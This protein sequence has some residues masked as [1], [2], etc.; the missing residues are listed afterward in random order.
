MSKVET[1]D[2]FVKPLLGSSH[3]I[4]LSELDLGS[5]LPT[6]EDI[7]K[8]FYERVYSQNG[9]LVAS[10]PE[11]VFI[12]P[13]S[14][15]FTDLSDSYVR[16]EVKL[17]KTHKDPDNKDDTTEIKDTDLANASNLVAFSLWKD[18]T[19]YISGRQ[20][21]SNF[22]LQLYE[23]YLKVLTQCSEESQ[24]KW[25][26]SGYYP[27]RVTSL[28]LP[29]NAKADKETKARYARFGKGKKQVLYMPIL[30]NLCSQMRYLPSLCE[31]KLVLTKGLREMRVIQP[32]ANKAT[33]D[34]E[35]TDIQFVVKRPILYQHRLK[36]LETRLMHGMPC[37]YYIN[38][39]YCRPFQIDE[40]TTSIRLADLL[41]CS[42]LPNYCLVA[43]I[44]SSDLK[45]DV[46]CSNFNFKLFGLQELYF[47]SVSRILPTLMLHF[48][49]FLCA[50]APIIFIF[51]LLYLGL[52]R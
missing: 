52:G 27:E 50:P 29:D 24:R 22:G 26:M 1:H 40:G 39:S 48:S 11:V 28:L 16:M 49:K 31:I 15:H 2:N 44:Q 36:A 8:N 17:V 41:L 10:N 20:V 21:N 13:P 38:N 6:Q 18:V 34:I 23:S 25:V 32:V 7:Q 42:Y 46:N 19:L 51:L 14:Q 5:T 4:A 12:S 35:L 3:K 30:T 37:N 45:G 9:S 43:L 33:Y 47:Q